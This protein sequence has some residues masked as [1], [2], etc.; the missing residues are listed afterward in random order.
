MNE[1]ILTPKEQPQV[2]IE[3]TT[4]KPDTFAGKTLEEIK[5]VEILHGNKAVKVSDFFDVE[6]AA[7]DTPAE[8]NI[9]IDGD[10]YNTKRIGQGMT[11]GKII[12]NGNVNMYVGVEMKGGSITVN[13]NAGPWAGQNMRGGELTIF[14]DASDYV[15]AS[16][17]GDWRG[18]TGGIITVHGNVANETAEFMLGGKIVVKGDADIMSGVHMNGGLLIIEGNAISRVGGEMKSGTIVVKGI[19][20][21]FLPGFGYLG[22]EKDIEVEGELING[23]FY[24]FTGD[25]ATKGASGTVYVAVAGNN[26]IIP[27]K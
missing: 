11:D 15:G 4:V 2:P 10:V 5:D 14:G 16:Y 8:T 23:T 9:V 20:K 1:I 3:A 12:V 13:G 26:H 17:R 19:V 27:S 21:E 7:G 22:I 18:M 25:F 6:G 24:K